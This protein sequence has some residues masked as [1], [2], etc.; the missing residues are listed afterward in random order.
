MDSSHQFVAFLRGINVGGNHKVPMEQLK[1]EMT[2]LGYKDVVTILNS[3]NVVFKAPIAKEHIIELAI[4]SHLEK[5]FG[6]KIPTLIRSNE[7]I[8]SLLLN[9]P[10]KGIA[11][12]KDV[13]LYVSFL[14]DPA[15]T[16]ITLPHISADSSFKIISVEEKVVC[17]VL[18]LS[19]NS[20]PK[21][22]DALE[23]LF[24]KNITTRNWNTVV[25]VMAVLEKAK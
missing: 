24:G 14:K 23:I 11:V 5:V 19:L 17:S 2:K 20:S 12:T 10:F 25:K 22:M 1:I 6:F 3:G 15:Q 21:A 13:R 16:I 9:D 8:S 18:D 4:S 7:V